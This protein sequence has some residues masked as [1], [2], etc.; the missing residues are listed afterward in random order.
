VSTAQ[1]IVTQVGIAQID[2]CILCANEARILQESEYSSITI[3]I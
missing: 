2:N 3:C 1:I